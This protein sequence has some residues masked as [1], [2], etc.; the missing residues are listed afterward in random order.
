MQV[1]ATVTFHEWRCHLTAPFDED[2]TDGYVRPRLAG[3]GYG[4]WG[5]GGNA[6]VETHRDEKE[7]N[8]SR[9]GGW[10]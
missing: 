5:A 6:V 1:A 10:C 4:Q 3:N 8:E 9:D 7:A 2:T